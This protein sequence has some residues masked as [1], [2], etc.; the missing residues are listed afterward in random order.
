MASTDIELRR[1]I[2]AKTLAHFLGPV[3][4]F[5]DDESISEIM[6]NGPSEI[7]IERGG[8]IERT[9]AK[10]E[11]HTALEAAARNIAQYVGKR[12]SPETMGRCAFWKVPVGELAAAVGP[13]V[14]NP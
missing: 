14:W 7:F 1:E 9:D 13:L 11:D 5:C 2:Y 4:K 10:F 6:I 3:Q 8:R 12:L